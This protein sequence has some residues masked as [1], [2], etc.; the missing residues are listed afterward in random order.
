VISA[1]RQAG[2]KTEEHFVGDAIIVLLQKLSK[3]QKKVLSKRRK[4]KRVNDPNSTRFEHFQRLKQKRRS[5]VFPVQSDEPQSS[6]MRVKDDALL[7]QNV[8]ARVNLVV[9][10]VNLAH[11]LH[12]VESPVPCENTQDSP[13]A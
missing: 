5:R 1:N 4:I 9:G 6:K 3:D 7:F 2:F 12:N 8:Q 10:A 13:P 11:N